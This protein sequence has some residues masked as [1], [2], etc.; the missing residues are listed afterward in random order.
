MLIKRGQYSQNTLAWFQKALNP[1]GSGQ[2]VCTKNL[3]HSEIKLQPTC[4]LIITSFEIENVLETILNTGFFQ[5]IVLYPR[6]IPISERKANEFLRAKRFGLEF[7]SEIDVDTLVEMLFQI[8]KNNLE[9]KLVV[10]PVVYPVANQ[11]IESRYKMIET[12]NERVREIMATFIPRYDNLMYILSVHHSCVNNK[13]KVDL[14]DI[15]YG[16]R[17]SNDLFREVMTWVEENIS[18]AKLS[19]REKSY[20]DKFYQ[21]W[22]IMEKDEYGYVNKVS[23]M[24]KF[25]EKWSISKNTIARNLEKFTGY[26]KVKERDVN[27]VKWIKIEV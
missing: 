24:M 19:S 8:K 15:Q 20:F 14:E 26:G 4:S 12:A 10:D 7:S 17:V 3:A 18:L 1:I 11:Y 21:L 16:A 5:R 2:N 9:Y 22:S 13:K 6:Y 27:N 25:N 23:F